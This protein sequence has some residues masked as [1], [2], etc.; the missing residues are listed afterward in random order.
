MSHLSALDAKGSAFFFPSL[1]SILITLVTNVLCELSLSMKASPHISHIC[2]LYHPLSFSQA[3]GYFYFLGLDTII[4]LVAG[5]I[6]LC[7]NFRLECLL[8]TFCI[9]AHMFSLNS[10]K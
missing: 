6:E 5:F 2:K 10:M 7:F 1:L 9:K 8:T 3:M 4:V